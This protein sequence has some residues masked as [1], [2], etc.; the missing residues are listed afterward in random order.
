L[1]FLAALSSRSMA[2]GCPSVDACLQE[3]EAAHRGTT[4]LSAEFVQIKRLRLLEEPLVAGGRLLVEPPARVVLKMERP[5]AM[6]LVIDGSDVRAPGMAAEDQA[7]LSAAP[8]AQAFRQFGALLTGSLVGLRESFE[9][10]AR[11]EGHF[12]KIG[13]VPR[14]DSWKRMFEKIEVVFVRPGLEPRTVRLR[15][16]FGDSLDITLSNVRRNAD[17]PES[18]LDVP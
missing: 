4:K 13:L 15:D 3:I 6:V 2:G 17:V 1:L 10:E 14:H 12:L 11:D 5:Q 8:V 16:A 9:I 18:G 7:A